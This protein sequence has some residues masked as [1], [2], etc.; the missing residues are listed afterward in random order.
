MRKN[1]SRFFLCLNTDSGI[2]L[3]QAAAALSSRWRCYFYRRNQWYGFPESASVSRVP[4]ICVSGALDVFGHNFEFNLVA[5]LFEERRQESLSINPLNVDGMVRQN[6]NRL[7]ELPALFLYEDKSGRVGSADYQ[8]AALESFYLA[9][10]LRLSGQGKS[11]QDD[12][13][14]K[15]S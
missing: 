6:F 13:R 14:D 11:E 5:V 12:A 4:S 2:L 10:A 15:D 1:Q 9:K 8:L 3:I 7:R